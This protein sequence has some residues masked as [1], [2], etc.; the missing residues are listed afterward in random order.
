[1]LLLVRGHIVLE[2]KVMFVFSSCRTGECEMCGQAEKLNVY[3]DG[4]RPAKSQ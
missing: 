1:M 3:I 4:G 2:F